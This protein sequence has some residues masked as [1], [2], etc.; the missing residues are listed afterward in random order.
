MKVLFVYGYKLLLFMS[1]GTY[2]VFVNASLPAERQARTR[3]DLS[4]YIVPR[5]EGARCTPGIRL[6]A[7]PS[8][9]DCA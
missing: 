7:R 6:A 2:P 1:I 5:L 9:G 4:S 3:S 8:L